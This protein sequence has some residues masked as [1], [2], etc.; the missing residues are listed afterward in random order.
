MSETEWQERIWTA[1]DAHP[2]YMVSLIAGDM[3]KTR[4]MAGHIDRERHRLLFI[5]HRHTG[6]IEAALHSPSVSVA[7]SQEDRNFYAAIACTASEVTDRE[8][9]HQIW[10]PMAGAWFPNGPDDPDA[11]LLALTPV[12]AEIWDGPSSSVLVAFKL[13]TAKILGRT[14]DLGVNATIDMR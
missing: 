5:T 11:G 1:L 4:P 6:I 13:A 7:I 12:S 2:V 9:L 3:L 14:P 10:T 8:L